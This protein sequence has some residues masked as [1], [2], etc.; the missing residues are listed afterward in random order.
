MSGFGLS[1]TPNA[2]Q[3]QKF[4]LTQ[5]LRLFL[6]LVQMNTVELREYLEEQLIENPALEEDPDS[7][8]ETEKDDQGES[9]LNELGQMETDYPPPGEFSAETGDE[10]TWENQIPNQDSLFEHL[11]WQLEMTDFSKRQRQIASLVIGN[12]NEDGYLEIGLEEIAELL[13]AGDSSEAGGDRMGEITRVAEN[14]RTTFDPIGVGSRSL[15]ECLA[16]QALD[17]GYERESVIMRVVESHIDDLGRKNYDNICAELD[18]SREEILEIEAAITSLEPKPGRPYYTKDTTRNIVPDFY[19]YRVGDELQMQSNRS[20]PKLR[21]SSYCRKILADRANLTGETTDYLREK[22]EVAQ[23]IV[24]CIEEREMTIRKVME[25]IVDEQREFFD[26]GS[27]HIK[28]LKLKDIADKVGIHEST[29]SRITSRKYIQC[30]QGVIELKKLF[31][32][33]V[34]SSNGLKVSIERIKS[35][36]REIVDEEPAQCAFS[37]EDI[38]RILSMKNVK[39][40]RRTVAKYRKILGIPS[41][42]KRLSKEV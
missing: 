24:R 32:R 14:I 4:I 7:P 27:A 35:M 40:A 13:E 9:L 23:R 2:A 28:P 5:H 8:P 34:R 33:G 6:S 37:D 16:A 12:I 17:L 21:I 42:S 3:K 10:T 29:V 31:S 36:I 18:I 19:V 11:H 39:V 30:P 26:H 41:S 25:K 15:S 1:Q 22:I 38:S 20:F